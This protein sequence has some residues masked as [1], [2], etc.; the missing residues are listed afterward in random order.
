MKKKEILIV[1]D[2]FV[3]YMHVK[4][5]LE[6]NGYSTEDICRS[7][8]DAVNR[9]NGSKPDLIIM[10]IILDGDIDGIEAAKQIRTRYDI[11]IIFLTASSDEFT[12][13]RALEVTMAGYIR[14]PFN[15]HELFDKVEAAI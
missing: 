9:I 14:K 2:E 1:E 4:I 10:D 12:C 13:K 15:K 5:L 11:P 6:K 7:G 3:S 8:E